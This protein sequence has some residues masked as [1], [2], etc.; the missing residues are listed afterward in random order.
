MNVLNLTD[1]P[2]QNGTKAN[3]PVI[4]TISFITLTICVS[5]SSSFTRYHFLVFCHYTFCMF[6]IIVWIRFK[7]NSKCNIWGVS[8]NFVASF[9]AVVFTFQ[10][11]LSKDHR[12]GFK[13][14]S[15]CMVYMYSVNS[16]RSFD[17]VLWK[18]SI[19]ILIT[20]F[21]CPTDDKKCHCIF[22]RKYD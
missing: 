22:K 2:F 4:L 5:N 14:R 10:L 18:V 21:T 17:D 20:T 9:S 6:S 1:E 8:L 19:C 11:S 3:V 16:F 12:W 7:I 13:I 15:K